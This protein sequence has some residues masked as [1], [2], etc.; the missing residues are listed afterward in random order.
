MAFKSLRHNRKADDCA[1]GR[2]QELQAQSVCIGR[3]AAK[4]TIVGRVGEW[5]E[6]FVRV[7]RHDFSILASHRIDGDAAARIPQSASTLLT[8]PAS[9]AQ[10]EVAEFAGTSVHL[11]RTF[12]VKRQSQN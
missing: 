8:F 11:R 1:V 12:H 4:A 9:P 10:T 3:S 7:K 6:R 5:C 2:E